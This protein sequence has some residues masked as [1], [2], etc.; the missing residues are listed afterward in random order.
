MTGRT[1]DRVAGITLLLT[2]GAVALTARGYTVDFLTDPIGA[3]A[4]PWLAAGL[5]AAGA[6]GM[7]GRPASGTDRAPAPSARLALT[8]AALVAYALLLDVIGF[9][10]ATGLAMTALS[11]VFGGRWRTGALAGFAWAAA[12][13]LLFDR[14]LDLALPVGRLWI[15]GG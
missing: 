15:I 5:I 2:A 10:V 12:L 1:A 11:V 9:V 8:V 6:L 13:W 14:L 4:L 7:L 3:R